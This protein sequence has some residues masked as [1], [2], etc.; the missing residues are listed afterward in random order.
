MD[1]EDNGSDY[2]AG[3]H[4]GET[5]NFQASAAPPPVP[6][7][8]YSAIY[9]DLQAVRNAKRARI[10]NAIVAANDNGVFAGAPNDAAHQRVYIERLFNAFNSIETEGEDAII[11]KPCKNGKLSQAALKF[12]QGRYPSAAIEEV[13]W[14]IFER[15]SIAQLDVRLLE[16]FHDSKF[17]NSQV[18]SNFNQRWS[19]IVHACARSKALCKMLLDA[20]YLDR[21]VSHPQAELK[22]KLNNKKINAQRDEQNEIGRTFLSKGLGK[23][24]AAEALAALHPDAEESYDEYDYPKPSV[25]KAASPTTPLAPVRIQPAR[26]ATSSVKRKKMSDSEDEDSGDE[27]FV[28]GRKSTDANR[29]TIMKS[30]SKSRRA[31]LKTPT[32][33]NTNNSVMDS[34]P[35]SKKAKVPSTIARQRRL[36]DMPLQKSQAVMDSETDQNY[37]TTI[38]RLLGINAN[39]AEVSKYSLEDLRYYARAYNGEFGG[40]IWTHKEYPGFT[41]FGCTLRDSNNTEYDHF[42][43]V[44]RSL[45]PLAA[46]RGDF[47]NG[48]LMKNA[49]KTFQPKLSADREALGA[50]ANAF[51]FH[52]G[53]PAP[54]DIKSHGSPEMLADKA[55]F[56]NSARQPVAQIGSYQPYRSDYYSDQN[57]YARSGSS[58]QYNSYNQSSVSQSY[59]SF[60]HSYSSASRS[61]TNSLPL[62]SQQSFDPSYGSAPFD[63]SSQPS[64]MYEAPPSI[65]YATRG[66]SNYSS[67]RG[68]ANNFATHTSQSGGYASGLTAPSSTGY[69]TPQIGHNT[70]LTVHHP[71]HSLAL[72]TPH[73]G[74]S[75]YPDP[76][77]CSTQQPQQ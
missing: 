77:E 9:P 41:G 64:S 25:G 70:S 8:P 15:A 63:Y 12:Q 71:D 26:A 35:Q 2:G 13:C 30:S 33:S 37:K 53:Y 22:M 61:Y 42:C 10:D 7:G 60:P 18:H 67:I 52:V 51:G 76:D 21:F 59:N 48:K 68:P 40:S 3:G 4:S 6:N 32:R 69:N 39:H 16:S 75:Q 45:M 72:H 65:V 17:E 11:D 29:S 43:E 34:T 74:E 66:V 23:E 62:G 54:V 50:T 20:P 31:T 24:E 55:A 28:S 58:Q 27:F 44:I 1:Q 14:E 5:Y 36:D 56:S 73:H 49:N 38:C 19:A 47:V 46:L 57:N